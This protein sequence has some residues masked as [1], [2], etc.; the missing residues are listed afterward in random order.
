MKVYHVYDPGYPG[1]VAVH[2][3]IDTAIEAAEECIQ[4]YRSD[5]EDE[6]SDLVEG[7]EVYLDEETADEPEETGE[8]VARVREVEHEIDDDG[9]TVKYVDYRMERLK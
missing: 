1:V 2:R 8:L 7:I 5:A 3:D 4:E 9:E 6:W